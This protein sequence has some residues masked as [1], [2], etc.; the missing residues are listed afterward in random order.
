MFVSVMNRFGKYIVLLILSLTGLCPLG[1]QN[2]QFVNPFIGTG[3]CDVPTL[4]GNYGGTFPGAVA[5]WGMI[6]LSPE[7]S[8]RPSEVGYYYEDTAVRSFSCLQHLS[9]YPNGSAGRL[10]VIFWPE[11][12]QTLPSDFVGRPFS[13]VSEQAEPGYYG[14]SFEN[15]D[16]VE[17]AAATRAGLFRY[18][19]S[20]ARTTVVVLDGKA[21]E[22]TD[23]QTVRAGYMHA[24]IRFQKPFDSYE[25]KGDTAFFHFSGSQTKEG[26]LMTVSASASSYEG[27]EKNRKA[28][29][30]DWAFDR[31]RRQTYE[32]WN[33]EL[34]CVDVQTDRLD[35][36][37]QFYTAL[38]HSFLFPNLLSDVDEVP[39]YGNFSP[40]DTFRTLHPL[41]SLLKPE[42]QRAMIASLLDQ[43]DRDQ[44]FPVVAM[45]GLH[46]IPV[47]VDA[48]MKGA[49]DTDPQRM[50]A[51]MEAYQLPERNLPF[52]PDYVQQGFIRASLEK[53]VSITTEYAYD[54]WALGRFAGLIG[55]DGSD[56]LRMSLN[57]RHLF[58][59]ESQ[60]L[61]PREGDRFLR[62]AGELGFQ[63]SNKWTAS[64]FVP[65]NVNDLIH[66]LGGDSCFVARLQEGFDT[67]RIHF[68]NEPVFHY[69]YLFTWAGRPD[70]TVR[71]VHQILRQSY[72]NTPG[73]LPGNDD[74]GAMSSWYVFS[75]LGVYPACPGS[76][77]YLLAE[78]LFDAVQLYCADG[79]TL[80]ITKD[81]SFF[82]A[83]RL[84]TVRLGGEAVSRWFV[85]HQE[86]ME[87]ETIGFDASG[88]SSADTLVPDFRSFER[89]YSVTDGA[90]AFKV[91]PENL[92]AGKMTSG[93]VNSL[94]FTVENRGAD[95]SFVAE[96]VADGRVIASKHLLLASGEEV[97]DTLRFTLYREGRQT[98]SFAE[99]EYVIQ[100]SD[101]LWR[102]TPLVCRSIAVPMLVAVGDSLSG[103]FVCKNV[104]GKRLTQT[105]PVWLDGQLLCAEELTLEP[106]EERTVGFPL[107]VA[108]SGF[109]RLRVLDQEKQIK[110]YTH[111][112]ETCLLDLDYARREGTRVP[113]QSG[114]GNDGT[115][116]GPLQWSG[117][118]VQTTQQAYITFP[119]S[120]SLMKTG[121]TL[122]L[123]TWIAPQKPI[124]R[125]AYADFFTKGD[126]TLMKMEGPNSLVFFAG[127]WGRGMCEIPVPADWYTAW[128]Q[129][130][131]VCTGHSLKIYLDGR[132]QQEIAVAGELEETEVPWNIGRNAE[133]PFS[134]FSD[135][136][137]GR[138]RIY[139]AA[140]S[141]TDI[142]QLYDEERGDFGR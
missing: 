55:R 95:G 75:S 91:Q 62:N 134:R 60:F 74:L 130:A 61:L 1:G 86:W 39:A 45:T 106:G 29:V 63:E 27:S 54:D 128:H 141:D 120:E 7:T 31:L 35:D 48:F 84:P 23:R 49:T 87:K 124:E 76:G 68:D 111:A 37:Q 140:L 90:P 20:E 38:Y 56:F 97:K 79:K 107:S 115:A 14:V 59:A 57:Y 135:M 43:Y 34:A 53:S 129:I 116:C 131:G 78:P 103:T 50:W 42:R 69:P 112:L 10:H 125:Q 104:T 83:G 98:V 25:M 96:L 12:I 139:G 122:T 72:R 15:G 44:T 85:S 5:P 108:T 138:S 101:S 58:D 89:P 33:R 22:V 66:L 64:Y 36:K 28:E 13:H 88:E 109:H 81:K 126:Y 133:M 21:L 2:A 52:R 127:G 9:G 40:W 6:Q 123:L 136:R 67:E 16:R 82:S 110:G 93:T 24:V 46:F 102:T 118:Y 32:A 4:W 70:L 30:P 114:F 41:L 8:V 80:S 94:P 92:T 17:M 119:P 11:K 137:F 18:T 99:K 65:H 121:K 73:G 132:L 117:N 19:S 113:D 47:L 71:Y 3:K 142:R 26:L 77:E 51:A 105:L 100:V